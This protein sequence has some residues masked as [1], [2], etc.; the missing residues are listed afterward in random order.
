MATVIESLLVTLGLDSRKFKRQSQEAEK[1]NTKLTARSKKE[2]K[3]RTQQQ[4]KEA[5]QRKKQQ[6]EF[7]KRTKES[8]VQVH[9]LRNQMLGLAAVFMGGY[10]LSKFTALTIGA[11]ANVGRLSSDI[12]DSIPNI[13]GWQ[14]AAEN[15]GGSA[16]D[17]TAALTKASQM[18]G[19]L[20][21]GMPTPAEYE[22]YL[23]M[24]GDPS[25]KALKSPTAFLLSES[26]LIQKVAKERGTAVARAQSQHFLGMGIGE[27]NLLKQG[28]QAV[29][30]Q[31]SNQGRLA[32]IDRQSANRAAALQ[33]QFNTLKNTALDTG[34][35]VLLSLIPAFKKLVGWFQKLAS[36]I[37][38]HKTQIAQWVDKAAS[39]VARFARAANDAAQAIGGW[40]N[41]F[42]ALAAVKAASI[43][44]KLGGIA[45]AI[46]GIGTAASTA[47]S[48]L[49]GFLG[50]ASKIGFAGMVGYGIG[51]E[52]N[53]HFIEGTGF[54]HWLGS[55]EG[56]VMAALGNKQAQS[57]V[58]Y[59]SGADKR[60][61]G[62]AASM[63]K[64]MTAGAQ[65]SAPYAAATRVSGAPAS[66]SHSEVNIDKIDIHTQATDANGIAR[67]MRPA[68]DRFL[69][70]QANSGV[71]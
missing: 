60:R 18:I 51:S 69:A 14:R 3:E 25:K 11:A 54:G 6:Q 46:A 58:D 28:P 21:S 4:K 63:R 61:A 64:T 22:G 29:Q 56:H 15:V 35:T 49:A 9:K 30:A 38:A 45:A 42:I 53:K 27:F 52:I 2:S 44:G 71:N 26:R 24:G 47:D 62:A 31:V 20:K 55:V 68:I 5:Q 67:S 32:G 39:A 16:E 65:N 41:V 19:A 43:V 17:M 37:N 59:N 48:L 70:P 13:L 36:W 10:G 40:K 34:R 57:A 50:R 33:K 12:G 66:S 1:A 23:N 8:V 7:N